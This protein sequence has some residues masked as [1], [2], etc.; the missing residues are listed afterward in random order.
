MPTRNFRQLIEAMPPA[1]RQKIEKRFEE[2]LAAMPLDE[3]RKARELTQL[4]LAEIMGLQE[5]EI[6]K[7]E[8]RSDVSVS[9]LAEYIEALG[10][11]LEIRAVFPDRQVLIGHSG[12][13][14]R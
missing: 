5:S 13:V 7:V 11:R 3:L 1:R 10:G 8:H 6:S 2:S 12:E 14:P 9:A 4:Q